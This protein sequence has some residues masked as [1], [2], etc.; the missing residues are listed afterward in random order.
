MDWRDLSVVQ[1][2]E[3]FRERAEELRQTRFLRDTLVGGYRLKI[4]ARQILGTQDEY[5]TIFSTSPYDPELLRSFLTLF[6]RFFLKNDPIV[7]LFPIY[8]LCHQHLT[9]EQYK[10][11]L[12]KSRQAAAYAL[13]TS[14]FHLRINEQ[15]MTPED[16]SEIWINGYYFHDNIDHLNFLKTLPPPG[17]IVL[18][19]YF[20]DFLLDMTKQKLNGC[21]I[22]HGR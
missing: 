7:N 16:V 5:E 9:D 17:D 15:D 2:L 20:F 21:L 12:A 19:I 6:R 1:R 18:E 14:C 8:N 11:Y 13:K 3:L 4:E 22:M 10:A